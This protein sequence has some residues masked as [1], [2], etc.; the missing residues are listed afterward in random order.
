VVLNLR[1]FC[2]VRNVARTGLLSLDIQKFHIVSQRLFQLPESNIGFNGQII[3]L[4]MEAVQR[5]ASV[6]LTLLSGIFASRTE[7][8]LFR[9]LG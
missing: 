9:M 2:E 3:S 8:R 4:R 5:N 6:Y 7:K 1:K